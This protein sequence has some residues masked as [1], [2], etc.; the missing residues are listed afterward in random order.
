MS[1]RDAIVT[2]LAELFDEDELEVPEFTDDLVLLDTELDSLGFAVL[3]ARDS[4]RS[5]ASIPSRS[6][7]SRSITRRSGSSCPYTTASRRQVRPS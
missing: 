7:T 2:T 6:R 4:T 3:V 1:L 5:W